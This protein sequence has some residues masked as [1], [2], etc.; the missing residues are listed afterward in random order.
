LKIVEY[1]V[2]C[3]PDGILMFDAAG[4]SYLVI[5]QNEDQIR[6]A[7]EI[8]S[9]QDAPKALLELLSSGETPPYFWKTEGNY[10]SIYEDWRNCLH[11][12][13]RLQGSDCYVY[14][15]VKDPEGFNIGHVLVYADYLDRLDAP[16]RGKPSPSFIA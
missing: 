6:A 11:P 15:V 14:T 2:S 3:A 16:K 7:H 12:A 4:N 10:S 13:T 8:A 5:A 9:D 1:D